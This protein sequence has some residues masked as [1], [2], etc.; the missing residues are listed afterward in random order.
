MLPSEPSKQNP[1]Q[2][3]KSFIFSW[4][5]VS[6]SNHTGAAMVQRCGRTGDVTM[7]LVAPRAEGQRNQVEQNATDISIS[8][9]KH[10]IFC[11]LC[12][13]VVAWIHAVQGIGGT[14]LATASQRVW[15]PANAAYFRWIQTYLLHDSQ[16]NPWKL[17]QT[18]LIT[19]IT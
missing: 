6:L 9:H 13:L 3:L 10:L 7:Q 11:H 2:R 16:F 12:V 19:L 1:N 17:S 5:A 18:L 8:K 15:R 14:G 4:Y